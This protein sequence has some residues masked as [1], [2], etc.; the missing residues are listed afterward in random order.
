[1]PAPPKNRNATRHGL[2]AASLP[3]GASYIARAT[4]ELRRAV[5]D[6]VLSRKGEISV[7]DAATVQTVMRFERH[8]MLCQRWLRM[9]FEDMNHDQRLRYSAEVA[10]AS[11]S[12]DAALRSLGIESGSQADLLARAYATPLVAAHASN[13]DGTAPETA[14]GESVPDATPDPL[15]AKGE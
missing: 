9:H 7:V 14:I 12:R 15:D 3:K 5:E 6:A 11:A 8:A 1:M 2:R 13:G 4:S 10:R